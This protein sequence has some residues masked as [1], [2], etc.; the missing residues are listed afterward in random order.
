MAYNFAQE[1]T[2]ISTQTAS[3]SASISFTTGISSNFNVY[4]IKIRNAYPATNSKGIEMRW[5]TN[6]GSTYLS[7]SYQW[8]MINAR[9]DTLAQDNNN[10]GTSFT[11]HF[12]QENSATKRASGEIILFN[13]SDT[14][15]KTYYSY[16]G[17][18]QNSG[19]MGLTTI[20]G[21]HS[22]T[23]AIN[24]IKLQYTTGN[25]TAGQFSLWGLNE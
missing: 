20:G 13:L 3:A 10:A 11:I 12:A 17:N 15:V 22:G 16:I 14:N 23:T 9:S 4:V 21:A 2:L 18:F 19:F 25:I 7:T 24:A 6:G 1:L 8:G 5:S